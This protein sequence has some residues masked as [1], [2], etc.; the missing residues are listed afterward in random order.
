MRN[1]RLYVL[2]DAA[3]AW[4]APVPSLIC[5][6]RA[7][8]RPRTARRGRWRCARWTRAAADRSAFS[9]DAALARRP[10]QS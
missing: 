9:S 2:Y 8:R 6:G 4:L 3:I 5:A 10:R 7:G 1:H